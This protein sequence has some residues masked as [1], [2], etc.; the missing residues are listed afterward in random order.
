MRKLNW[1]LAAALVALPAGAQAANF[2]YELRVGAAYS[3]NVERTAV[4][5]IET[6]AAVVGMR[7]RGAREEGRL[8]YSLAGDANYLEYLDSEVP[9]EVIGS[10]FAESSYEILPQSFLWQ[11]DGSFNQVRE[12]LLRSA[13]PGNR[14]NVLSLSTGPNLRARFGDAFEAELQARYSIADFS[15]RDFD[16]ETLGAQLLLGRRFSERS[17]IGLGASFADVTYDSALGLGSI[18]F[19]RTEIFA[20]VRAEGA[21]TQIQADIGYSQAEGANV[22]D[23]GAMIRLEAT[24]RLTPFISGFARYVQEYPTSEAAAFVPFDATGGG[25]SADASILTAAPRV[26]KTAEIGLR[27]NRP[28]TSAELAFNSNRET[29]LVG[30]L[31]DRSFETARLSVT[32]S[33]TPRSRATLFAFWSQEDLD[34]LSENADELGVGGELGFTF[35]RNLGVDLRLEHRQRD[36]SVPAFEFSEM[37]IGLFLRWGRV[38]PGGRVLSVTPTAFLQRGNP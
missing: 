19:E 16:S 11:L 15:E 24:R 7:L 21:R 17:V 10:L 36:S 23:S 4:D 30:G 13:A 28:R 26:A 25:T 35:G 6:A 37:S 5:E 12:D 34:L 8:Q 2:E 20:R 33:M 18:D 14:D 29:S 9:G 27:L 32:R 1:L 31:G 38:T 3:N 22:D